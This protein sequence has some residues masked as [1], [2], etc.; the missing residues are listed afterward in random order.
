MRKAPTEGIYFVIRFPEAWRLIPFRF[1]EHEP[2]GHP[3]FWE[4]C[5]APA[6]AIA[7]AAKLGQLARQQRLAAELALHYDGFPRG[8]VTY[9]DERQQFAVYHGHNLKPSMKVPRAA[10]EKAF[11]IAGQAEWE[12]D[13]HEQCSP[14]SAEAIWELLPIRERWKTAEVEF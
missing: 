8:R 2:S 12:F 4:A 14:F 11:D 1:D 3:D 10:I 7:W 6:L 9:V 13:E 5:V